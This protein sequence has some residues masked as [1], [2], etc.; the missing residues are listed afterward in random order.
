MPST[1]LDGQLLLQLLDNQPEPVLFY[2]PVWRNNEVVDFEVA[3][4]N[5]QAI[6]TTSTECRDLRGLSILTMINID[7]PARRLVFQQLLTV[8]Q[9]GETHTER[10]HNRVLGRHFQSTRQLVAGGVLSVARDV[11]EEEAARQEA[12]R[13]ARFSGQ[14]LQSAINGVFAC[15]AIRNEEG[16]IIDLL[17]L[18]S[19]PAFSEMVSKSGEEIRGQHYLTL[20]PDSVKTGIFA[21]NC[22]VINEGRPARKEIYY[23]TAVGGGWYDVSL[24]PLGEDELLVSCYYINE[25]K[26]LQLRLQAQV[27]ELKLLSNL[28]G[29]VLDASLSAI[30]VAEA[31]ENSEGIVD[32]FR[33]V[34]TNRRYREMMGK[35]END[36][37][38]KTLRTVHPAVLRTNFIEQLA[39]VIS[40]GEAVQQEQ[41]YAE[42][43]NA[44]WYEYTAVR[45]NSKQVVVTF[46]DITEQKNALQE[47]ERQRKLLNN[48]LEHSPSGIT[49]TEVIRNE[50]GKIVDGR[51]IIANEPAEKYTGIPNAVSLSRTT[52]EIDP[53][54]LDSPLFQLALHTLASGEPFQTEYFF[55]PTQRWLQL[56]VAR[57]DEDHLINLVS[58]IT[59]TKEART[60]LEQS[61]EELKR[62][63]ANLEEFAYA[64]S[65]DMQE[66][67]RKIHFFANRIREQYG[68]VLDAQA[69]RYFERLEQAASR[70]R[71]LIEDL[72]AFSHVSLRPALLDDTDLNSILRTVLEDLDLVIAEKSATIETDPLPVVYGNRRQLQQLFQN[73]LANALKYTRPG[74]PARVV[75]RASVQKGSES[76]LNLLLQEG[77]TLFHV[78]SI[79]DNG[80]GFE[81][82]DA[83]RIFQ[84]FQRLHGN[85]EYRGT[86]VGLAIARKVVDNHG[87]F[88][89]AEGRPGEGAT[90]RVYLPATGVQ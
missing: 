53:Q 18:R 19:N 7:E 60:Q 79:T 14:V 75:I 51:T 48:I 27:E 58:D 45:L 12:E 20:F 41:Y 70:M 88:I 89:R 36:Y 50:E 34:R 55:G 21:L 40:T 54:I 33:V 74:V 3:Y 72:L 44:G 9:S 81:Q 25:Q 42:G 6:R 84:V 49:V 78:I 10:V 82:E 4:C 30:Y 47:I 2:V 26:E 11:T 69:L 52:S 59:A 38:D 24:A 23:D 39:G 68:A 43:D 1:V 73:L 85:A 22:R 32:D 65:H 87:G 80:I 63:N 29:S 8:Y 13:Q 77:A 86:G 62:T 28:L 46:R 16:E 66:P 5:E 17:M 61:V 83:E 90:F 76:N 57:M 71:M 37:A 56:S 31:I 35:D 64:A 15:R 67:I